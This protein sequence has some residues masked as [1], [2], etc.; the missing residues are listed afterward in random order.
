[1]NNIMQFVK[2]NKYDEGFCVSMKQY[3]K[4]R[5]HDHYT[6]KYF[7]AAHSS[8]NTKVKDV[9]NNIRCFFH[10]S[11]YDIKQLLQAYEELKGTFFKNVSCIATNT[12]NFKCIRFGNI[13]IQDSYAHLK[14]GLESLVSLKRKQ[15]YVLFQVLMK[16]SSS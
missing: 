13:I 10:N 16:K 12:E 4:I 15:C 2:K 9:Y 3:L 5:D 7:G 11:N 14:S 6:G 1:M 8:C